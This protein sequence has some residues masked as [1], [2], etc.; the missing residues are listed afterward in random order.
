[1]NKQWAMR[2]ISRIYN[3][4]WPVSS[5]NCRRWLVTQVT[6]GLPR[7]TSSGAT[8]QTVN[9][10][11]PGLQCRWSPYLEPAAGGDHVSS[12]CRCSVSVPR[13]SSSRNHILMSFYETETLS[14]VDFSTATF[15]IFVLVFFFISI[16]P[17]SSSAI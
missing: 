9:C 12:L 17:R 1:M 16:Q 10:W 15:Y 8:S 11:W 4:G 14:S 6:G 7:I 3:K 5:L 13:H 2:L